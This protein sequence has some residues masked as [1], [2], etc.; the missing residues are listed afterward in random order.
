MASD[1][2]Q[3]FLHGAALLAGATAIVKVLGALYKIPLGNIIDDAGFGYFNTAYD[4][5]SV[6]LMVS[7]AGLPVAMSRMIAEAGSL[8]RYGQIR[9]IYQTALCIFLGLG[10]AGTVLMTGFCRPL[11]NWMNSPN[12]WAAIAALG[13]SALLMCLTSAFRGFFQGQGNMRPTSVS[14]VLEAVCKLVVGLGLAWFIM[15]QKNDT[16]LAAG[17]AIL[18]VTSGCLIA[19]LY[20]Y[21]AY[22]RAR[23][24]MPKSQGGVSSFGQTAKRLLAIAIPIT[25]GSAGLQ[26]ITLVDAKVVMS[27]LIGA[28]GFTQ[29]QADTLKGVYNFAQTIFNLPY[30]FVSPISISILPAITAQL[31]LRN[32]RGARRT[33]ESAIRIMGLITMPCAVGLIVLAQPIMAL[34]RGY[35]GDTLTTAGNLLAVLGVSLVFTSVVMLTNTMMPG[36]WLC[37]PAGDEHVHWRHCEGDCELHFGGQSQHQYPGRAG[38]HA[39]LLPVHYGSE[40]LYHAQGDP[41]VAQCTQAPAEAPPCLPD[42]GRRGLWRLAADGGGDCQQACAV[43]VAHCAGCCGLCD[44]GHCAAG[45][46]VRRLYAAAQGGE[47]CKAPANS[48]IFPGHVNFLL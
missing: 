41:K 42:H 48:L 28:A 5:Y 4:I 45:C 11:A 27:R 18:G 44:F 13:P 37:I 9:R 3:S 40:P 43:C 20:M 38:G 29:G 6:L 39:V 21:G 25:I 12:S 14:Q 31:T 33:E 2:K 15:K 32:A 35:T 7:T 34:L 17:G 19:T 36:P 24:E 30:A 26:I 46:H 10:V 16:A 23:R 22:S 8:G 47:N 1:K